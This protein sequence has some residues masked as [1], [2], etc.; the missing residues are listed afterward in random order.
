MSTNL[1]GAKLFGASVGGVGLSAEAISYRDRS[2]AN[3]FEIPSDVLSQIDTFIKG[4]KA[5]GIWANC[6]A[7]YDLRFGVPD[8]TAITAVENIASISFKLTGSVPYKKDG[9][10]GR[11][12]LNFDGS[13]NGLVSSDNLTPTVATQTFLSAAMQTAVGTT[14]TVIN[15][16]STTQG[17]E[18]RVGSNQASSA[19]LIGGSPATYW[20]GSTASTNIIPINT[21]FAMGGNYASGTGRANINDMRVN[22]SSSTPVGTVGSGP[23]RLGA[24]TTSLQKW[25]GYIGMAILF[26]AVLSD[27]NYQYVSDYIASAHGIEQRTVYTDTVSG[28]SGLGIW[29]GSP[30]LTIAGALGQLNTNAQGRGGTVY[31]YSPEATPNR[32]TVTH[33]F[34]NTGSNWYFKLWPGRGETKWYSYAS[35]R[36]TSW[37]PIGGNVYTTT[38]FT[39]KPGNIWLTDEKDG[40]NQFIR[41]IGVSVTGATPGAGQFSWDNT[42]TVKIRMYDSSDPNGRP[43]EVSNANNCFLFTNTTTN[44]AYVNDGIFRGATNPGCAVG[45]S[46]FHVGGKAIFTDCRAEC[47]GGLGSLVYTGGGGFSTAGNYSEMTCL[48]CEAENN[49]NDGF[50]IHADDGDRTVARITD[51]IGKYNTDEGA[52]PHESTILYINGGTFKDNGSGGVASVG[53]STTYIGRGT[54]GDRAVFDHN[55]QAAH[56]TV[57]GGIY[58]TGTTST[59][60]ING[61]TANNNNGPGVYADTLANITILDLT[62]SGNA[63]ANRPP[64]W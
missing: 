1:F 37:T 17:L 32:G 42:G 15:F 3:G 14:R 21:W 28:A 22:T 63:D 6:V 34:T 9:G 29:Q 33:N 50:G 13:N 4:L 40:N 25:Q 38:G 45:S 54:A 19:V 49:I 39:S 35:A 31:I 20:S 5:L 2:L 60:I 51:C 64:S 24:R 62:V 44:S 11:G 46:S 12:C 10:N 8:A 52:S 26:D 57:E 47:N 48:R 41:L 56:S 58:L 53:N 18:F 61:A 30:R 55:A 16:G 7:F 43:I 59:M 36:V 27:E 23:V